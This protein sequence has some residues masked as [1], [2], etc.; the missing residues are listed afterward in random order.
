VRRWTVREHS[1]LFEEVFAS[2]IAGAK[3]EC[4]CGRVIF[5]PDGGWDWDEGELEDLFVQA[6][7]DPDMFIAVDYSVQT[8]D[9]GTGEIVIGCPCGR[10][11]VIEE[12]SIVESARIA[13]Y[14]RRY[15]EARIGRSREVLTTLDIRNGR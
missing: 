2:D 7:R 4:V 1:K 13:R 15:H 3:R 6:K 14:I 10:A 12:F 9:F 8:F 5:N 11:L